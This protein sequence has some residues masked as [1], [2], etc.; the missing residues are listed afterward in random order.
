MNTASSSFGDLLRGF[1][2]RKK[3]TQQ[4]LA[5]LIGVHRNTISGW[6]RGD[7][8]PESRTMVL[9]TAKQLDLGQ[10]ETRQLLEASLTALAPRW[11]VPFPRNPCFT[12]RE[13]LLDTLHAHLAVTSQHRAPLQACALAGLGGIGKTQLALEYAYRHALAYQAVFWLAAD[14]A[15]SL[16]GSLEQVAGVLQLPERCVIDQSQLVAAVRRWLS[17]HWGWLV[18]ADNVEQLELLEP[19]LV[20]ARQGALLLTT[21]LQALSLVARRLDLPPL[22]REEGV[23]LVLRRATGGGPSEA[24]SCL[25]GEEAAAEVVELLGGL[26]LAL[27]QVGAYL[28]E[29][30]CSVA[31]YLERYTEHRQHL[32]E[33]R[34]TSGGAHPASVASTVR[35]A[36]EQVEHAH[37]AAAELLQ[38]CACLQPERIPEEMLGMGAPHLGPVLGP[39]V[40]DPVQFDLALAA[41]RRFSLISRHPE[42]STLS[43]HRLVQA[44]LQDQLDE[45]SKR[46]WSERA[47]RVVHAA[48][49]A[50][51]FATWLQCERCLPHALACIP[52]LEVGGQ[53]LPEAYELLGKAGSYLVE[54]GRYKEAE[55]L[56]A[57][58]L[59]RAEAQ[60]GPAHPTLIPLLMRQT[61]LFWEQGQEEHVALLLQRALA[62]SDQQPDLEPLLTAEL[63]GELAILAWRRGNYSE[64][65]H[66]CRRALA[67]AEQ[68]GGTDHQETLKLRYYLALLLREQGHAAEAEMVLQQTVVDDE[69]VL[70]ATHPQTL[71]ALAD[72]AV[73]YRQQG[74][75]AHA[76]PLFQRILEMR[77]QWLGAEHPHTASAL[78]NVASMYVVQ[79]KYAQAEALVQQ[80][81][82]IGEQQREAKPSQTSATLARFELR[83]G[84]E[85][86]HKDPYA[87][88][89]A[90]F[91]QRLG[92]DHPLTRR[93]RYLA[94]ELLGPTTPRTSAVFQS[95]MEPHQVDQPREQRTIVVAGKSDTRRHPQRAYSRTIQTRPVTF[96]CARCQST[97]TQQRFPGP[98]PRY[99]SAGCAEAAEA[100]QNRARVRRHRARQWQGR[101]RSSQSASSERRYE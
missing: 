33:R 97:V 101:T 6:E 91:E 10:D 49:P 39:L 99:C 43:L 38:I 7:V 22:S 36:V 42:T 50:V 58:A 13:D 46:L 5:D 53:D 62:L 76:E 12:G 51:D 4:G 32:L 8:L 20:P 74:H 30:G 77:L 37:P 3:H 84:A 82:A 79:A 31:A 54:R 60:H 64:G 14:S 16:F 81:L 70:G 93:L 88:A 35:L 48:F 92:V 21:R 28:E 72:L 68:T 1:R 95:T 71:K 85:A 19:L 34:G 66:L 27:D 25:H 11:S 26:P 15:E 96:V 17:T 23:A 65:E 89:R 86:P 52:L 56:L 61:H 9:E 44:V 57:Q 29:T 75:Y 55:P 41:L 40:A 83:L 87:R 18:I 63:L 73:L 47:I 98:T 80:A 59:A 67:L 24:R 45:R 69:R 100:E 94:E 2:T 78:I 90:I